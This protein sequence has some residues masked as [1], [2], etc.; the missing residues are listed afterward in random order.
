MLYKHNVL[1]SVIKHLLGTVLSTAEDKSQFSSPRSSEE[2]HN[3]YHPAGVISAACPHVQLL[4]S[5]E[6]VQLV[7]Q[8]LS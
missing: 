6:I 5:R 8:V 3:V 1:Y 7:S 4:V 2:L